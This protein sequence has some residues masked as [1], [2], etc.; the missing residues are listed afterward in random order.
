M[1]LFGP[2]IADG[3]HKRW[4]RFM[5][6]R[7]LG[8][9]LEQSLALDQLSVE[10]C[11]G[12]LAVNEVKINTQYV[13]EFLTSLNVPLTLS[14]GFVGRITIEVPW[15][16]LLSEPS[17]VKLHQLELTLESKED[18]LHNNETLNS[19]VFE[20][21]V[22]SIPSSDDLAR[23]FYESVIEGPD[24]F[25]V[26]KDGVKAV[27]EIIEAVISR[28]GIE[29][30]ES[31][32]RLESSTKSDARLR[33]AVEV[34]LKNIRFMK[35]LHGQ[36]GSSVDTST[37][38][39]ERE[40]V[41][42]KCIDMSGVEFFTDVY[43]ATEDRLNDQNSCC[44]GEQKPTNYYGSPSSSSA[45][46]HSCSSSSNAQINQTRNECRGVEKGSD[47][48]LMSKPVKFAE[49]VGES[50][51]TFCTRMSS[52]LANKKDKKSEVELF[53][54]GFHCF[55]SP[56]QIEILKGFLSSIALC[57]A[58]RSDSCGR[59]MDRNDYDAMT[60]NVEQGFQRTRLTTPMRLEE[61]GREREEFQ[62]MVSIN[63]EHD[64]A[65][66]KFSSIHSILEA[67]DAAKASIS[68]KV[69]LETVLVY[70]PHSDIL[71]LE[72]VKPLANGYHE[73][74]D[75]ISKEAETFFTKSAEISLK[76]C[77][78]TTA[79]SMLDDLYPKDHL[80]VVGSSVVFTYQ[81]GNADSEGLM[82]AKIVFSNVDA[83]EFLTAESN[84]V[85]G[86]N[87]H[88]T[89][90]DFSDIVVHDPEPQLKI[91]IETISDMV[92]KSNIIICI[93]KCHCELDPSF[94]ERIAD[95]LAPRPFFYSLLERPSNSK[96]AVRVESPQLCKNYLNAYTIQLRESKLT[97]KCAE[98]K[99][100][101][102]IPM[103]DL[104]SI[105]AKTT[106]RQRRVHTEYIDLLIT[107]PVVE[108]AL[109]D[110]TATIELFAAEVQGSFCGIS[111]KLTCCQICQFLWMGQSANEPLHIKLDYDPRN[112]AL[113]CGTEICHASGT[114]LNDVLDNSLSS[115]LITT[116][117]R[118]EGPFTHAHH[119]SFHGQAVIAGSREEMRAFGAECTFQSKLAITLNIPL[120]RVF[121]SNHE[122]LELLY[123]RLVNGL[124]LWQPAARVTALGPEDF[125]VNVF[126]DKVSKR[127]QYGDN[128][129]ET[130]G[131]LE[132]ELD[133]LIFSDIFVRSKAHLLSLTLNLRRA[134]V[135]C[136][137]EAKEG[138][139][140]GVSANMTD[141]QFFFVGGYHGK[142][143]DSYA[144]YTAHTFAIGDR[145]VD[146]VPRVFS[147]NFGE[148]NSDEIHVYSIPADDK[149][150]SRSD[151]DAV[152]VA[153]HLHE[154]P[155]RVTKDLLLAIALRNICLQI[156]PFQNPEKTWLL[157]LAHFFNLQNDPSP[158]IEPYAV[159]TELHIHLDN[160]VLAY[161]HAWTKRDSNVRLRLVIGEAD[162]NS[163]IAQDMDLAKIT[164]SLENVGVFI[165]N[166]RKVSSSVRCEEQPFGNACICASN[167][168]YLKVVD[169][170]I[171]RFECIYPC[172]LSVE[173]EDKTPPLEIRCLN[174]TIEA[175]IRADTLAA[176]LNIATE[177][178]DSQGYAA[179][180][181]EGYREHHSG[182]TCDATN[183]Y[184]NDSHSSLAKESKR[185][186]LVSAMKESVA[187]G[188]R[189]STS[190]ATAEHFA[191]PSLD[192][193]WPGCARA[194]PQDDEFCVLD[195]E[196]STIKSVS[197]SYIKYIG[198]RAH[199]DIII[200]ID[201]QHFPFPR[202]CDEC[203]ALLTNSSTPTIRY[204]IRDI[205][206][207]LHLC[208]ESVEDANLLKNCRRCSEHR[209]RLIKN[210]ADGDGHGKSRNHPACLVLQLSKITYVHQFFCEKAPFKSMMLL[211][212]HDMTL[213]DTLTPGK[214]K[215]V[216][217]QY[218]AAQ[219]PRGTCAPMLAVRKIESQ[220]CEGKMRVSMLPIKLN[221]DQDTIDFLNS[222]LQEVAES[223]A[224]A[225]CKLKSGT[226]RDTTFFKEFIFSPPVPIYVDY[227]GKNRVNME[228][229][230]A[231]VG[232]I[233]GFGH[234]HQ[235]EFEL[236][237]IVYRNGLLGVGR[238]FSV[239]VEEWLS[240]IKVFPNILASFGP[241]RPVYQI[242][243][244][245]A[246][247]FL[248]PAAE[249]RKQDGNLIKGIQK[250]FGS[251]GQSTAA[252]V[253]VVAQTFLGVV[254][255]LAR[256]A[257]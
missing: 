97:V 210:Q 180:T 104:P 237:E 167:K 250:G 83:V 137:A 57:E 26:T 94:V 214:F 11:A 256:S 239:A 222:F 6:H 47:Q 193:P 174:G 136:F 208:A 2:S 89:L 203:A 257:Y 131:D 31:T 95:L 207:N 130:V 139:G 105:G 32:L 173:P 22:D 227:H 140:K 243:K 224:D 219:R 231:V 55:I 160:V 64:T 110:E 244:A 152:G 92:D 247:L 235:A 185:R 200:D 70:I 34:R 191:D 221:V 7:Y 198:T 201:Y 88:I 116:V 81:A 187:C 230:G 100:S 134:S 147:S 129:K 229:D 253:V 213:L 146:S 72:Y 211:T 232:V 215:K 108:V 69:E 178:S 251:F 141:A 177:I 75:H 5:I 21:I 36:N 143:S 19:S 241:I 184:R 169:V 194:Y 182:D 103:V 115:S 78:L 145:R 163:A 107:S 223:S 48:E 113:S 67:E 59:K 106:F 15:L 121:I 158:G 43:T 196:V 14:D 77:I 234:L 226:D 49:F 86:E 109:G 114:D 135:M 162:I 8:Q 54:K 225:E 161:D 90:L 93:R 205:S 186:L 33:T 206:I 246:D 171:L 195:S 84:P 248:F 249:L 216:L 228:K 148:W 3:V 154:L 254:Q 41:D 125:L 126:S 13:N 20:S 30:T 245:V 123:N 176:M 46:F 209:E 144:Y 16:S 50:H 9:L 44:G 37:L 175:W 181:N 76:C 150:S 111:N 18:V 17:R 155:D 172:S 53:C 138:D 12:K 65:L 68:L 79:R 82:C 74:L 58:G 190:A 61:T 66:R 183:N 10:L 38:S 188:C 204:L 149:F 236:N 96:F 217:Y 117:P 197:K 4:C 127:D 62:G 29:L 99:L 87:K 255:A 128:P 120:L 27:A 157:C 233:A 85:D 24:A 166:N 179:Y 242:G 165:S 168:E 218:L 156:R 35:G 25:A 238:C 42:R 112:K 240:N 124:L 122:F 51:M 192:S 220:K 170:G 56:S 23:S 1:Q 132:E 60:K 28:V 73:A 189:Y 91:V 164:S 202:D 252:G 63:L 119:S 153:M 133:P 118:R 40:I 102:R 159:K 101:L 151:E 71:S 98:F 45:D 212:I 39:N 52:V 142:M 199:P 80:R